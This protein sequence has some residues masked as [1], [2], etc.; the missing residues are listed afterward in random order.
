MKYRYNTVMGIHEIEVDEQFYGVLQTMDRE[1]YNANRKYS[2][3]NPI[4][5]GNADFDGKWME[6]SADILDGLIH[7]ENRERLYATLKR[8]THE[9]QV[10]IERIFLNHEKIVDIARKAG[11]S[12]A[13]IENRLRKIYMRLKKYLLWGG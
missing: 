7:A 1:E 10:L 3:H 8:L 9:Q 6:D 5:F 11:V 13:A 12:P 2:R 4:S